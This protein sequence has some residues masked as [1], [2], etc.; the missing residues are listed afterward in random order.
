MVTRSGWPAV[1]PGTDGQMKE[2]M[3]VSTERVG[4]V[5]IGGGQAG[6]AVGHY[7]ARQGREFVI[8]DAGRHIGDAWRYRWDSLRLFTP[9]HFSGLPGMPFPAP[10]SHFPSKDEMADYLYAYATRFALP[11]RLETRVN[12][13]GRDGHRYQITTGAASWVADSA[14][15]ATGAAT[16]PRRPDMADR[17]A[18]AI[19]QVHSAGYRNPRQLRDGTVLIVG[20]GNSG[21]E[22]ALEL[23]RTHRVLLA[24]PDTG[25][26][27]IAFG[28]LVF[29]SM[30]RLLTVDNRFGRAFAAGGSGKGT[31]LVR[32]RAKDLADA[33]VERVPRVTDVRH[34]LPVVE[35][36]RTIEV[37]NVVWCTGYVHDEYSWIKLAILGP[38]GRL[39]HNRGV[40][41]TEPGLYFVG[42]PFQYSLASS[43]VAGVG[44]DARYVVQHIAARQAAQEPAHLKH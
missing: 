33:G 42:L 30:N 34:G 25:R 40:I 41:A 26:V 7:L 28:G 13:L 17:L 36:G 16:K 27:P 6:L 32:V 19:V 5:V 12:E 11:V 10:R 4:T 18:S 35:D 31:P 14:V 44:N 1:R 3:D 22:I 29:R 8:L 24:G 21:A 2:R 20:A 43:L 37:D 9:A 23:A 15:V 39:A 38:D